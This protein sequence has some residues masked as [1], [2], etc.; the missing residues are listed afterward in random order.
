[1]LWTHSILEA[2]DLQSLCTLSP[3]MLFW[4]PHL[5]T[6]YFHGYFSPAEAGS[7]SLPLQAGAGLEVFYS[8]F[9]QVKT[10]ESPGWSTLPLTCDKCTT[11]QST[12]LTPLS[13]P[14]RVSSQAVLSQHCTNSLGI[15]PQSE[16]P[17]RLY[18]FLSHCCPSGNLKC[19]FQLLHFTPA[20]CFIF[21]R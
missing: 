18:T 15:L 16:L 6:L 10:S 21:T 9:N 5:C 7:F 1:M 8:Q 13:Q 14:S 20:K 17:S 12:T 19:K 4:I 3:S 2:T 11:V